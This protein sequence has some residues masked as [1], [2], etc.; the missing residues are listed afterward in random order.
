MKKNLIALFGLGAIMAPF[1][2]FAQGIGLTGATTTTCSSLFPGGDIGF[3]LCQIGNILNKVVPILIVLGVV[4]FVWGVV[5]YVISSDEEAKKKGRNRMIWG[6]IG[7]V[8]IVGM[9]G[10]VKIVTNSFGLGNTATFQAPT[11]PFDIP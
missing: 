7:L 5:T 9:W 4:F 1:V 8:V 3:V 11:V 6:L 10:L 2:V